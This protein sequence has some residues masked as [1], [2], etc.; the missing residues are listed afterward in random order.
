MRHLN[1]I[2]VIYGIHLYYTFSRKSEHFTCKRPLGIG[3]KISQH[4]QKKNK[5]IE[6]TSCKNA[7][8][9]SCLGT[10]EVF[11]HRPDHF[12]PLT[13]DKLNTIEKTLVR[14]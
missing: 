5:V 13:L 6:H 1:R 10:V 14:P 7:L 8:I 2:T 9:H 4:D 12:F 3:S 11:L